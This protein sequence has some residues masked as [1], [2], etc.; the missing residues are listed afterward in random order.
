MRPTSA[1]WRWCSAVY[2]TFAIENV[3]ALLAGRLQQEKSGSRAAFFMKLTTFQ[4][5]MVIVCYCICSNLKAAWA[6][7]TVSAMSA[8]VCAALTK[9]AS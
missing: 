6:A 7:L 3:T 4:R 2:G 9:P 5:Q 1:A 8:S